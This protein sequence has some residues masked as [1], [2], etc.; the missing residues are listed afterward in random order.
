MNDS[1][2]IEHAA[3]DASIPTLPRFGIVV[4]GRNEGDRLRRCLTSIQLHAAS[5]VYVD[6]GSTDG[7]TALAGSM[8]FTVFELDQSR[9]FTA[10]RG[11]NAGFGRLSQIIPDVEFVQFLDGDSILNPDWLK[12]AL[13]HFE[14]PD[15]A[16]VFGRV[17]EINPA[18][19]IYDFWAHH[20]WY[21]PPGKVESCGGIAM[22]RCTAL[23]SVEGFDESL[24]AGEERD[25]C[26]R[27]R[28]RQ[29]AVI[30]SIDAPM[31]L[32]ESNMTHFRQYWRRCFRT[33][34]AY[35]EV[36]N[37]HPDWQRRTGGSNSLRHVAILITAACLSAILR[38][39][40]PMLIWSGLLTLAVARNAIR[41]KSRIGSLGGAFLYSFHHYMAKLPIAMGQIDARIRRRLGR[42]PRTIIE[43]R[44]V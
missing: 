34:H 10:A 13:C 12:N 15:V 21:V 32:H 20:D 17:E 1:R 27:I 19:S 8:G 5:A 9:P 31:A 11:R 24:I 18:K 14:N 16:C 38:S 3:R 40:W 28:K 39:P 44:A 29:S 41:C 7:S 42:K 25:L 2:T 6:S 23:K 33:G 37:R 4:I 43:H 22:F 30:L 26:Y 36:S 35:I